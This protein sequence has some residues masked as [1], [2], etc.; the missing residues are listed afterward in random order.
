VPVSLPLGRAAALLAG[1][2]TL[3]ACAGSGRS[4]AP[5]TLSGAG[6][7]VSP[8]SSVPSSSTTAAA[9]PTGPLTV[10]EQNASLPH[11]VYRTHVTRDELIAHGDDDLS[12]AGVWT[13][14]VAAGTYR[15]DCRPVADPGYDCGNSP[16]TPTLKELGA[17]RGDGNRAWFIRDIN[18]IAALTGC[19]PDSEQQNGCG[20]AATFRL[21]WADTSSGPRFSAYTDIDGTT[22][23]ATGAVNFTLK[24]WQKIG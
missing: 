18:K 6:S 19:I 22:R 23:G 3:A 1:S 5:D 2:L 15:L 12:N 17:L 13:L 16:P 21:T 10:P 4:S 24:P 9:S 14:T 20:T 11:G 7:T 8:V